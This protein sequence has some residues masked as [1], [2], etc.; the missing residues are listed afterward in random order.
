MLIP[1]PYG[2]RYTAKVTGSVLKQCRC[3]ACGEEY[4]YTAQRR[5]AGTGTSFLW[6]NDGGAQQR[7]AIGA[8]VQVALQLQRAVDP[9]AC[10]GC[11][12]LQADMVRVLKR[13]RLKWI[14]WAS[15]PMA[16]VCFL[17][18]IAGQNL[19][20]LIAS[21]VTAVSGAALGFA[22]LLQHDPNRALGGRRR[23]L[24]PPIR[25]GP[26]LPESQY[27]FHNAARDILTQSMLLV[28]TADG[29]INDTE[30]GTI[31]EISG[32][33]GVPPLDADRIRFDAA[34]VAS[35]RHD[36]HAVLEK[37]TPKI[38]SEEKQLFLR[39][40]IAVAAADGPINAREH[41]AIDF[42]AQGLGLTAPDK[43]V[44]FQSMNQPVA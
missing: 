31:V 8:Q 4:T 6:L 18:G 41:E 11:G 21:L 38:N 25:R 3:E 32:L 40:G 24:A 29:E 33:S 37:L 43:E 27:R 5:A 10:P 28:A 39:Y 1:I 19:G 7:A 20:W 16:L 44:A 35:I 17:I 2:T 9:V 12:W 13:R 26:L 15:L 36:T 23:K 30:V 34:K 22:W 42:L 14:L